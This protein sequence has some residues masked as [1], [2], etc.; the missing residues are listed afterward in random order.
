M[1]E[2]GERK[3]GKKERHGRSSEQETKE[4]GDGGEKEKN[5]GR[6][7]LQ[8]VY[9]FSSLLTVTSAKYQ[10][11]LWMPYAWYC[12]A[13]TL[14]MFRQTYPKSMI[15][16]SVWEF[17]FWNEHKII[18]QPNLW[19]SL[20]RASDLCKW[21]RSPTRQL[22]GLFRNLRWVEQCKFS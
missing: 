21:W 19:H 8:K 22:K 4:R 20:P 3:R 5:I 13:C 10:L 14:M 7:H 18:L 15:D 17:I 12:S 9:L 1:R 16:L 11:G 2:E 6:Y